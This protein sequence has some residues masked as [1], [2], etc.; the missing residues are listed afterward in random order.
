MILTLLGVA[1][2]ILGETSKDTKEL[3]EK[4]ADQHK[5]ENLN[6]SSMLSGYILS[7]LSNIALSQNRG[8]ADREMLEN[9]KELVRLAKRSLDVSDPQKGLPSASM[10]PNR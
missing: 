10:R 1:T 2:D 7:Q 3:N 9:S 6:R 8:S 4:T 5:Q